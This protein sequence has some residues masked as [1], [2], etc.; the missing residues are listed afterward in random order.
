VDQHRDPSPPMRGP[1]PANIL[2]ELV[3]AAGGNVVSASPGIASVEP[4]AALLA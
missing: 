1:I 2:V 3:E 4:I